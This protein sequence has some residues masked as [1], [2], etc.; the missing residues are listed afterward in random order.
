MVPG[1]G[2]EPPTRGFSIS[3]TG[4]RLFSEG[5]QICPSSTT[6]CQIP[7]LRQT[8]LLGTNP[9][10]SRRYY[11]KTTRKPSIKLGLVTGH[12][13]G[14]GQ[15]T[16]LPAPAVQYLMIDGEVGRVGP[17]RHAQAGADRPLARREQRAHDQNEKLLPGRA[18][19][20]RAKRLQ[21]YAKNL[22]DGVADHGGSSWMVLHPM[23]RI[24]L[25]TPHNT[26]SLRRID[27]PTCCRWSPRTDGGRTQ[28]GRAL[29]ATHFAQSPAQASGLRPPPE[30]LDRPALPNGEI[31]C[32]SFSG[33]GNDDARN[34]AFSAPNSIIRS[35]SG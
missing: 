16:T 14:P 24:P 7:I 33:S 8:T 13:Q 9:D 32:I 10:Q 19:D 26:G 17:P 11:T 1:G 22:G 12:E 35:T 20:M 30:S 15:R 28:A 21:P 34:R 27:P 23:L 29:D 6:Y 5:H 18:G 25:R 4:F 31:R 3:C 2:F